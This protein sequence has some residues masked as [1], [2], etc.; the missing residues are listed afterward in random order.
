MTKGNVLRTTEKNISWT[1]WWIFKWKWNFHELNMM[2][3][4]RNHANNEKNIINVNRLVHFNNKKMREIITRSNKR[5]DEQ[6]NAEMQMLWEKELH[7]PWLLI[8]STTNMFCDIWI[9]RELTVPM[10]FALWN[11]WLSSI[12]H[13]LTVIEPDK[14]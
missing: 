4:R 12:R 7:I 9:L 8:R 5:N 14:T 3:R 6:W 2:K 10:I 13:W 1:K 11:P